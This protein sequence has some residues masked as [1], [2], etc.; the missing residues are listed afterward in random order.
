MQE[1][2]YEVRDEEELIPLCEKEG[3]GKPTLVKTANLASGH[4]GRKNGIFPYTT[5]HLTGDGKPCT[6][7]SLGHL[8]RLERTHGVNV[9]GFSQEP[10]NPDS[11]RDLP[12]GR[13]GG[14]DYDGPRAP[15]LN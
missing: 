2:F 14:R 4:S 11:P 8:R 13:P 10:S 5:N 1:R 15:W 12:V 6:V 7:E 9:S 3:C